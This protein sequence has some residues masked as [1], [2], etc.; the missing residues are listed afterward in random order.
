MTWVRRSAAAGSAWPV[1]SCSCQRLAAVG[2]GPGRPWSAIRHQTNSPWA[3]TTARQQGQPERTRDNGG[4][5]G[6]T[7]D[8]QHQQH[9]EQQQQ[10]PRKGASMRTTTTTTEMYGYARVC[11]CATY[12]AEMPHVHVCTC[13]C[14]HVC[15]CPRIQRAGRAWCRNYPNKA[16]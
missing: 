6:T 14:V 9:Q 8:N 11:M 12:R 4:Q 16:P 13:A 3:V 10:H 7:R 2:R 1:L 15:M 5:P